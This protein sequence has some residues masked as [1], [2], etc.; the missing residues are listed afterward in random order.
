MYEK[1]QIAH[2]LAPE[3]EAGKSL[4][5]KGR[6]NGSW[7]SIFPENFPHVVSPQFFPPGRLTKTIVELKLSH[8]QPFCKNP[9]YG[10]FS[11][12][13]ALKLKHR[14][15]SVA[16]AATNGASTTDD[17]RCPVSGELMRD[18]VVLAT[19][20]ATSSNVHSDKYLKSLRSFD[21][22]VETIVYKEAFTIT[23]DEDIFGANIEVSLQRVDMEY[24]SQMK[25]LSV[26]SIML[27]MRFH[28]VLFVIDL[29][30]PTVYYLDSLHNAT[31]PN[32]KLI[33]KTTVDWKEVE[34]PEQPSTVECGFFVMRF[35]KDMVADPSMLCRRDI[36]YCLYILLLLLL[37]EKGK[38]PKDKGVMQIL[39]C[40]CCY[41]CLRKERVQRT[42][43]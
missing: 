15:V 31:N 18:P 14:S 2:G 38:S 36:L 41:C 4:I 43:E 24:M 35:M 42:K 30:Y 11:A 17:F 9:R 6:V 26:T 1:Y 13:K 37:F 20:Q 19:G 21:D 33:I 22:Y 8:S 12:P 40:C 23:L 29:S 25:E 10:S 27:Y 5:G 3:Q 34:C 28:W 32:L 16:L 7:R 39:T